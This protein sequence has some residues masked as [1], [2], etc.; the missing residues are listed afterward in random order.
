MRLATVLLATMM[1]AGCVRVV[2]DARPPVG[3]PR[4]APVAPPVGTPVPTPTPVPI[5]PIVSSGPS[6]TSLAITADDAR[7]ALA[8]FI[9]SCPRLVARND[10]SKLTTG[11]D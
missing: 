9:E 3:A 6:V 11:A 8:S 1:L 5:A 2:P 10:A 7:G 4:P